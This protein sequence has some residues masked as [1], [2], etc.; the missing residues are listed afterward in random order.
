MNEVKLLIG[1]ALLA[2]RSGAT[3]E[4][5]NPGSGAVVSRSAAAGSADAIA[6]VDA[7]VAAFPAW[8]AQGPSA[9]RPRTGSGYG[10]DSAKPGE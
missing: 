5:C 10:G 6:A 8:S 3:F 2:A 1:G 9:R 7:A 4:R